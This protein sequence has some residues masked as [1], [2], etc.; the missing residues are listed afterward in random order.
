MNNIYFADI[1]KFEKIKMNFRKDGFSKIHFL[2]DFDNTLTKS[3]VNLKR[4]ASLL[5]VLREQD[6]IL[7]KKFAIEDTKLFEKFHPIEINPNLSSIEKNI[8]MNNWWE[9]TFKLLIK[10]KLRKE[11]IKQVVDYWNIEFRNL[12][13]E[14][15]LKLY[16]NNIPLIIISANWLWSN[17]INYFFSKNN[18]LYE[19]IDIISNNF[20]W[21][22]DWLIISYKK[23]IIHSFNKSETILEELP[24]IYKKINNRRNVILLWDSLWDHHMIDWFN[25]DNLLKIWYLNYKE[26]ELMDSYLERYDVVITW[27]GDMSFINGFLNNILT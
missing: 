23:P 19:N 7:W 18:V 2:A 9:S 14:L 17:S 13:K 11:S 4:T 16:N 22:K 25:Y 10:Y 1:K 20:L 27:D 5:S 26:D 15:F 8:E 21:D 6:G 3:F 24:Q 12:Y